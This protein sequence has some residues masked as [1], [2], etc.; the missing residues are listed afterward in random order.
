MTSA[1]LDRNI[2]A[3]LLAGRIRSA[4]APA[5]TLVEIQPAPANR[6]IIINS[7]TRDLWHGSKKRGVLIEDARIGPS[8]RGDVYEVMLD[9]GKT[10]KA[11]GFDLMPIPDA[12]R[13]TTSHLGRKPGKHVAHHAEHWEGSE[14]QSLLFDK[15]W[16]PAEA[17]RWA[18]EHGY[19]AGKVDVTDN[20]IRLRQFTP[21][22]GTEKRTITLGQGIKAILE[23]I[24]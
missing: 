14:I 16:T 8:A 15:Q 9:D 22:D 1:K 5:G 19:K 13:K 2:H 7:R 10:A 18:T 20:Y 24:K 4:Y 11:Y 6:A 12:G 3:D 23:Q 17:K 21:I